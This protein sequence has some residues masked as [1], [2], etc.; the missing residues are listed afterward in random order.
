MQCNTQLV[1]ANEF[2]LFSRV[3]TCLVPVA[4]SALNSPIP[5]TQL[6]V[7]Q[8]ANLCDPTPTPLTFDPVHVATISCIVQGVIMTIKPNDIAAIVRE[9]DPFSL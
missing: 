4:R 2:E 1:C 8:S 9:V 5:H 6:A 3:S 7:G